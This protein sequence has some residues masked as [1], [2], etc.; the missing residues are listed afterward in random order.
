MAQQIPPLNEV[1]DHYQAT[2][3]LRT[4]DGLRSIDDV[5]AQ[6]LVTTDRELGAA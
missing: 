1:V 2:G 5:T 3:V 4:V 6:L